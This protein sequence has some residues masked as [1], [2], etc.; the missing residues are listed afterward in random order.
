MRRETS[1][2]RNIGG[3]HD[4]TQD[5]PL[6]DCCRCRASRCCC[7]SSSERATGAPASI[8]VGDSDLGG[9]VTSAN[10]PEAGVAAIAETTIF[11]PSRQDR[12]H[13]R[14]GPCVP[15]LP[16]AN[17]DVWVRGYGLV[18]LPRDPSRRRAVSSIHCH[19]CAERGRGGRVLSGAV[20]VRDARDPGKSSFPGTGP[21]GNGMPERIKS[22]GQWIAT[23]KT[24]GCNSCHQVGNK[25]T[26]T[27]FEGAGEFGFILRSVDAPA[28]GRPAAEN[29]VRG[30]NGSTRR[31]CS[32]SSPIDRQDRGPAL[33]TQQPQ[34]PQGR[35]HSRGDAVGLGRCQ[36]LPA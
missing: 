21:N 15:E 30:I 8:T 4:E 25:P 28:A 13:R 11:P 1:C 26:R 20:L 12:R 34:R 19:R 35:A 33:P 29:M 24:H 32:S 23:L 5:K 17:Y 18:R 10:G 31:G 7:P 36:D 2:R 9:V 16:K 6:A 27:V 3:T 14:S 22:Q